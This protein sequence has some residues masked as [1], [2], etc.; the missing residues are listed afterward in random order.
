M[1]G[2]WRLSVFSVSKFEVVG[3]EES[4]QKAFRKQIKKKGKLQSL[5]FS[6][7]CQ[8]GEVECTFSKVVLRVFNKEQE[9]L[10]R[11]KFRF[12]FITFLEK[13]LFLT[14]LSP[15]DLSDFVHV[16]QYKALNCT[17]KYRRPKSK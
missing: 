17:C 13:S 12:D 9:K 2:L 11:T 7:Q 16:L 3:E 10:S 1:K 4:C 6:I 14:N 5:L 15:S 8:N